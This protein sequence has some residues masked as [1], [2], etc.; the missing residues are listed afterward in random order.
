[1]KVLQVL[2]ALNSGGVERGTLDFARELVA[3]GHESL[4]MS[5]GGR[6]CAELEREG[7]RHIQFPVHRKSLTSLLKVRALRRELLSLAPDVIH[8]RSRVPAWMVWL[9]LRPLDAAQRPA[10]VSTFHGLYSVNRYSAI[11][12]CGDRVI[13]ISQAVADYIA[14]NY[15][16]IDQARVSIIHRGVDTRQFHP[17]HRVS[18]A[19][20]EALFQ[21]A[22][23]ARDKPLLLMPARLS[24]WKG[25]AQFLHIVQRLKAAGQAC[26][27]LVVGE[28]TPGKEP[29]LQE[30]IQL[31]DALG[32]GEDVSFLGHRADMPDLYAMASVVFN[33]STHPEPFGRTVIEALAMGTPVVAFDEGG[34]AESLRDCLPAGLVAPGDLDAAARA[35]LTF[36]REPPPIELPSQFTLQVQ[37]ERTLEVYRQALNR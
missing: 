16:Q 13:A 8:V 29:Y 32:L 2:P 14:G 37:A 22:P 27:G 36:L 15:P 24:P 30:L 4:V 35:S 20:R 31:R 5:N 3:R 33:L 25:Q 1:M 9:A 23:A 34:P 18:E 28:P 21:T 6:L 10:L 11:M 19:W 12:G 26:H 17:G 7:S